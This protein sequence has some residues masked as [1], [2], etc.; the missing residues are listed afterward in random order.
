MMRTSVPILLL[1]FACNPP[2][3]DI[4]ETQL[5]SDALPPA[6]ALAVRVHVAELTAFSPHISFSRGKL[7]SPHSARLAFQAQGYLEE[8]HVA[9]GQQVRAGQLLARLE[10]QQQKF[11]VNERL[12]ALEQAKSLYENRLAEFGDS[13][14]YGGNWARIKEKLA[15]NEGLHAAKVAYERA[16]YDLMLTELRAP[17][18]GIVEGLVINVHRNDYLEVIAQVVEYHLPGIKPGDEAEVMPLAH[19]DK[20]VRARVV[21]INP[22]VN[23]AGLAL[24]RLQVR[25]I[26]GLVIGMNVDVRIFT[27][28]NTALAI[29][30]QAVV[31]RPDG[32]TVAFTYSKGLAKWNYIELGKES[33]GI[34]AVNKGL[35][36]GDSVI[37]TG[38]Y[39]LAHDSRV[40]LAY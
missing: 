7:Q 2:R 11:I 4:S 32:R 34:V 17:V 35:Q 3:A 8:L 1:L 14:R 13:T 28:P 26:E 39:Q 40:T 12:I 19:P 36:P 6:N 15:L 22:R 21:E 31:K 37:V 29:P 5:P 16:R 27:N 20:K 38:V 10:N 33:D 23:E 30:K 18:A 24:I 25:D 9:N